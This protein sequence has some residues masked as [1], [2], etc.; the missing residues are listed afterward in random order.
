[1]SVVIG[2]LSVE[3]KHIR[4]RILAY[5]RRYRLFENVCGS[6][7]QKQYYI[8][9]AGSRS[10]HYFSFYTLIIENYGIG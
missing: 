7:F 1:M 9:A 5:I 8:V 10:H 4:S 3:K 6:G 2:L